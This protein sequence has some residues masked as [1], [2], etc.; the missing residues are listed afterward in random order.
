MKEEKML[1]FEVYW[2]DVLPDE[3]GWIE[4]ERF[5]LGTLEIELPVCGDLDDVDILAAMKNYTFPTRENSNGF[6]RVV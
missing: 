2:L 6:R 4:N 3:G 1:K 5:H